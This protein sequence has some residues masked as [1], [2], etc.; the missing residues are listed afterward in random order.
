MAYEIP[1]FSFTLPASTGILD[2]QFRFVTVNASGQAA[3]PAAG[4]A[5]VGVMT[6]KPKLDGQ[7]ATVVNDGIVK[8]EAAGNTV[9]LGDLVSASS[10]GRVIAAT[11]DGKTVGAVVNGSSGSTGRILSILLTGNDATE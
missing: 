11:T 4:G 2:T 8:V 7:A 3:F 9:G 5:V 6:N 1:G 10:L